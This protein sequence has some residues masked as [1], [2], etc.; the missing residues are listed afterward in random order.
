MPVKRTWAEKNIEYLTAT[1]QRGWRAVEEV[2]GHS[3]AA[4]IDQSPLK[5]TLAR[6]V[7]DA[8]V[9]FIQIDLHRKMASLGDD[10]GCASV[11]NTATRRERRNER[12]FRSTLRHSLMLLQAEGAASA[13]T[14]SW[15][16]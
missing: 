4:E 14:W 13:G 15:V 3:Y 8:P 10:L 2:M 1:T 6:V 16:D 5:W 7:D 12:H 9:S 11:W